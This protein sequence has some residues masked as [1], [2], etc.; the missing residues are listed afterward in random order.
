MRGDATSSKVAWGVAEARAAAGPKLARVA[1]G[2]CRAGCGA[3]RVGQCKAGCAGQ[4][5]SQSL[6]A[7]VEG[8][9]Y[10]LQCAAASQYTIKV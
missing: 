9:C 4:K 10:Y 6:G 8:V 5:Q 7:G 2:V 1:G 3:G